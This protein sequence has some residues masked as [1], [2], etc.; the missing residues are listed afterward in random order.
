MPLNEKESKRP[1]AK[2]YTEDMAQPNQDQ[3]AKL[4]Q[5]PMDPQLA[6]SPEDAYKLLEPGYVEGETG[7]CV[8]ENG[9]GYLAVN[10][11]FPGATLEM[12]KW[13]F[14]WHPLEQA[15]YRIWNPYCHQSVAISDENREKILDDNI[16]LE[17]KIKDVIHFVMEDIGGGMEDVVI[18]FMAP[19]ALGFSKSELDKNNA[20]IIGGY[21]LSE[22]RT[23][24]T[25]KVP[26]I[27]LHYFRETEN[28]LESRT[29]F[30]MGYRYNKG[31]PM[32]V[33]PHGVRV[34]EIV[35]MGLALHN[36]EEY[37]HLAS[38][39]PKLY[40]ELGENKPIQ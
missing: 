28:G 15:R 19:E 39:L 24:P 22:N 35:P 6:I 25:G 36:V 11:Q 37:S 2:Y 17:E 18:H 7:Y 4:L 34:P 9:A 27:M 29:R 16:P 14:A 23:N 3:I 1:Y 10:N 12:V 40:K 32:C 33:L 31:I 26:A 38:F 21:G 13:W 30:W 5:G 20:F 8:L